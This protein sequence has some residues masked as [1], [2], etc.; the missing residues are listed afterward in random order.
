[1]AET[2]VDCK[3]ENFTKARISAKKIGILIAE[4]ANRVKKQASPRESK[5]WQKQYQGGC[6]SV[7][8][9]GTAGSRSLN[10]RLRN[11]DKA[12][13]VLSFEYADS[14]NDPEHRIGEVVVCPVLVKKQ[15]KERGVGFED[16][17]AHVLV[18]G[19]IHVLGHHHE[20]SEEE[21]EWV[22]KQEDFVLHKLGYKPAHAI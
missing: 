19:T 13:D 12:T 8:F 1:M 21:T 11:Q 20:K 4:T 15:A 22:H 3:V 16:E 7:F 18:H 6:V 9:V 17:L 14:L 2:L 5:A 10:K